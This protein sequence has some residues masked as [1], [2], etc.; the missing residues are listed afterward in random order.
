MCGRDQKLVG[1]IWNEVER[2]NATIEII[3]AERVLALVSFDRGLV[4]GLKF[5]HINT[6]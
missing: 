6:S 5:P 3:W 2:I 1:V 4:Q